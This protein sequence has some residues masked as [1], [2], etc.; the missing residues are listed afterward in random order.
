LCASKKK[1]RQMKLSSEVLHKIAQE[2]EA[3]MKVYLNRKTM[4]YEPVLDWDDI[5]DTGFW[6]KEARRIEKKWKDY[7][8]ITK[9]ESGDA[10][11]V[12]ENFVNEVDDLKLKDD[13]IKIL[14]RKSPFANFKMEVESSSHRQ[15]WFDFRTKSYEDYISE[16]LDLEDIENE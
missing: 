1:P 5:Q 4:E 11:R 6:E 3:G 16:Q 7:I 12:M 8:I 2:L 14:N 9:M 15:K 13:L 10:F